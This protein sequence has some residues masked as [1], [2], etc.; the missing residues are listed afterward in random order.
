ML[1]ALLVFPGIKT[2]PA[3]D[4]DAAAFGAVLGDDLAGFAEGGAIDEDGVD[5][6]LASR[7]AEFT[8]DGQAEFADLGLSRQGFEDGVAGEISQQQDTIETGH[9][10]PRG[11]RCSP[12]GE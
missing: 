1:C 2:Q 10:T 9:E 12:A 11:E 4:E 7:R 8:V 5:A 6:V 3:F